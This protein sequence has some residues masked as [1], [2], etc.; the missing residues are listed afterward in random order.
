MLARRFSL[1]L[2]AALAACPNP[3]AVVVVDAGGSQV[4]TPDAGAQVTS[5]KVDAWL[6]WQALVTALPVPDGGL[7]VRG[8]A[9]DEAKLLREVGLSSND[10]DRV[11]AVVAAVV[12]ERNVAKISGAE[13]LSHFKDGLAQLSPEQRAKAEAA[14]SDLQAKSPPVSLAPVELEFGGESVRAVLAREAEVT[15]A[16][17]ALLAADR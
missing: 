10:A 15:R 4:A 14:V 17:D 11:E 12:A 2:A 8:R 5:S 13:A 1:L 3:A 9:R 7:D 16:W 6:R